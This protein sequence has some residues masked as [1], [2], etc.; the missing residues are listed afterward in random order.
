MKE[1]IFGLNVMISGF[2]FIKTKKDITLI[3]MSELF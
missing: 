1:I 2:D 3:A